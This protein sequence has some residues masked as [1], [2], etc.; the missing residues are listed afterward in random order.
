MNPPSPAGPVVTAAGH[1]RAPAPPGPC[2]VCGQ[3][4]GGRRLDLQLRE[5]V[6]PACH[7]W[8]ATLPGLHCVT[9][10]QGGHLCG[11]AVL[12]MRASDGRGRCRAHLREAL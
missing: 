7:A 8:A 2:Y 11:A 10:L 6:C 9:R 1:P 5:P 12:P 4:R 3:E